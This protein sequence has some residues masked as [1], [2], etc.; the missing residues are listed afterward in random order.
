M[1]ILSLVALRLRPFHVPH[2]QTLRRTTRSTFKIVEKA[3]SIPSQPARTFCRIFPRVQ[4]FHRPAL[5]RR[6]QVAA[7]AAVGQEWFLAR[8]E[9]EEKGGQFQEVLF[10]GSCAF[11]H[12]L[13]RTRSAS[14]PEAVS[15]PRPRQEQSSQTCEG[16]EKTSHPHLLSR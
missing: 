5:R 6:N 9:E 2:L 13:R 4:L 1:S 7:A 16:S 10:S 14:Q 15:L 8:E 3:F 12:L 11:M